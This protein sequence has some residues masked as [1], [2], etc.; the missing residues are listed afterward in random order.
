MG[1][2]LQ[3]KRK[4]YTL[5]S[6]VGDLYLNGERFSYTL[7][8]TVR[9]RGIK[10]MAHTAI[11]EGTYKVKVSMSSR[12]KRNMPM[13]YTENNGYELKQN[14]IEF[15]GVRIHGGNTHNNTEGCVL[16]AKH[17]VNADTIYGTMERELTEKLIEL[18]G[19]GTLVVTNE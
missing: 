6:T 12:F 7:E 15:K 10:I 4:S 5:T 9:G 16:V 3:L 17:K 2:L 8:D 13:I 18:G 11:P 1:F 14:D 19:E